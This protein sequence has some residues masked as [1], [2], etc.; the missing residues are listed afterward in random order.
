MEQRSGSTRIVKMHVER[1]CLSRPAAA[2][3]PTQRAATAVAWLQAVSPAASATV[4]AAATP[5]TTATSD[6]TT[7]AA[8][9]VSA[10]P[11]VQHL[12]PIPSTQG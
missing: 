7:A 9:A 3:G 5:A 2:T 11:P 8:A 1:Q 10:N 6:A 12:A 4:S